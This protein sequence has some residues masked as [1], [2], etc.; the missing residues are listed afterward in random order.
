MKWMNDGL[1][2]LYSVPLFIYLFF[3]GII[4]KGELWKIN[5]IKVYFA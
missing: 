5:F 3:V 4:Y 2:L 1:F